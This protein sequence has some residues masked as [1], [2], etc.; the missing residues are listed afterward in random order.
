M[1]SFA[2]C[3]CLCQRQLCSYGDEEAIEQA[4]DDDTAAV[5]LEPIQGEAV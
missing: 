4:I 5:I 3:F 2:S 1:N